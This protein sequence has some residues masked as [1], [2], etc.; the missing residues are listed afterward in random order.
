MTQNAEVNWTQIS[1]QG[2]GSDAGL[3]FKGL[4][5]YRKDLFA[6]ALIYQRLSKLI[7]QAESSVL[8]ALMEAGLHSALQAAALSPQKFIKT[9]GAILGKEL[10]PL[11]IHQRA[12]A[13]RSRL[14]VQY[15]DAKQ[16]REPHLRQSVLNPQSK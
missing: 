8:V 3:N 1:L 6:Q 12:L 2:M 7:P 9:Y 14:L 5:R 15:L 11:E 16:N 10:Q 13:I 4:T